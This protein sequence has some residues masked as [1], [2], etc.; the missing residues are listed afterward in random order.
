MKDV[1]IVVSSEDSVQIQFKQII[2]EEVNAKVT[3]LVERLKECNGADLNCDYGITDVVPTYCAVTVYFDTCKTD[4][5]KVQK[6]IEDAIQK[7]GDN[8]GQFSKGGRLVEIP[9]CYCDE[10]FAPDLKNVAEYTGLSADEVVFLHHSKEYLI[11]MLGF[12]PGFPYLGGMDERLEV[13]RLETPRLKIP[14]GSVAIGGKQTGVYPS[15]SPGGWRIIGRTPLKVFDAERTPS[16]LYEAGDKIRFVPITRSEFDAIA[17]SHAG[18]NALKDS[19]VLASKTAFRRYV[20]TS[21][22]KVLEGGMCTTV[23]DKGRSGFQYLGIGQSGVM[24]YE[25]Y[26][27]GNKILGNKENAACLEATVLGPSIKFILP[28]E[29]VI[30]GGACNAMIDDK[31]VSMNRKYMAQAGSILKCGFITKGLRSYICFKGGIL[32]PEIFG[33]RATNLKSRMGGYFGRKL[34]SEDQIAIGDFIEPDAVYAVTESVEES[35]NRKSEEVLILE[36]TRGSQFSDFS[37]KVIKK[38][39]SAIFTVSPESDRMGI[40]FSGESLDCGKTDIISDAIPFGAVQITSKGLPIVMAADRQTTGG[41][42]K[43]AA[44]TRHSMCLLSQAIPGTK[45]RFV[46]SGD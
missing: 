43:I 35:T 30:T 23:Q 2:C 7:N 27:L 39:Q 15:D 13:P 46:I 5:F 4:I 40:R 3:A 24:D 16:C 8:G 36:C 6:I 12:L 1:C 10:E 42:A 14:E 26:Q 28:C 38:F 20:C 33:S 11:Y 44:V 25:S 29:F 32:V 9:V 41:Y 34:Q 37:D 18:K 22:I 19:G 31:P 17:E 45:V 21:G